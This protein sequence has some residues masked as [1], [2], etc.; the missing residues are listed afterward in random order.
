MTLEWD[1]LELAKAKLLELAIWRNGARLTTIPNPLVNTS[2]KLSGLALDTAYTF[3]LVLKTSA[4]VYTSS[5]ANVRTHTITDTSGIS[6]CFGH[7]E[8]GALLSQAQ[9]ALAS[10]GARSSAKIQ[11]DTTHFVATS[12]ASPS[13]PSGGPGVEYQKALQL[14]IPVVGPEWV[15]ACE[16]EKK[17]V[18]IANFYSVG[19]VN[20]STSIS[21][22]SSLAGGSRSAV[23]VL[24]QRQPLRRTSTVET[25]SQAT[26]PTIAV[27]PAPPPEEA[28]E[29]K[30]ESP[31]QEPEAPPIITPYQG[32]ALRQKDDVVGESEETI[33]NHVTRPS[34]LDDLV[35]GKETVTEAEPEA[36]E[37]TLVVAQEEQGGD[38]SL[39][40]IGL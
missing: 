22:A 2:T 18:P 10:M 26:R 5:T 15:L 14:N 3:H 34:E 27:A 33:T 29:T 13:N 16:K 7:I 32:Q 35:A 9:A 11:I 8:S 4:G 39:E 1:K 21:S 25:T 37:P 6:V 24:Q 20:Q 23:S 28:E 17:L 30:P 38:E 31:E 19:D 12:S 40:E 36:V